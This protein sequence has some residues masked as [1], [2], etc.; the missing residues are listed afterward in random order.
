MFELGVKDKLKPLFAK[1]AAWHF[2]LL[3][4]I[5]NPFNAFMAF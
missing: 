4:P 5:G 3:S 2:N 1:V